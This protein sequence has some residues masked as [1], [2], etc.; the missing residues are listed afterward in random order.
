MCLSVYRFGDLGVTKLN[1]RN[2]FASERLLRGCRDWLAGIALLSGLVEIADFEKSCVGCI[3][4][5]RLG[6]LCQRKFCRR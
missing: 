3:G 5:G 6:R 4:V 1:R 2:W